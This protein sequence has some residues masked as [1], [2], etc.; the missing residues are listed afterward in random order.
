MGRRLKNRGLSF[1]V[2]FCFPSSGHNGQMTKPAQ[3]LLTFT[4]LFSGM[5]RY[6]KDVRT[7]GGGRSENWLILQMNSTDRLREMQ[8]RGEGVS[9]ISNFADVF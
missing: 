2:I 7:G 1:V 9:K 8:M 6:L 3:L 5:G 4:P